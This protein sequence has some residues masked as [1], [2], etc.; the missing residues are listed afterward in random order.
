[1]DCDLELESGVDKG[2][3]KRGTSKYISYSFRKCSL[4]HP[5]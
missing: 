1:M 3:L 4:S 2:P 5:R